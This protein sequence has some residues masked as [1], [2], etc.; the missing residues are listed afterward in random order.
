MKY[1]QNVH[2]R[3]SIRLPDYDYSQP[4]AYFI[5]L[6]TQG[7]ERS[8]GEIQNDEMHLSK[9][10]QIVWEIWKSLPARCPQI[11]VGTAIVMPDH[12][13]GIVKIL[14][15][16][17]AVHEPPRR[18][19]D[20]MERRRMTLPLVVG[21]LKMNTTKRINLLRGLEGVPVW[22]RNCYERIIRN[23]GEYARIHRYIKANAANSKKG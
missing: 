1:D 19:T 6:V 12:F 9:A 15:S 3:H 4:G 5:T 10:G 16:V 21:Y 22:Q 13:H 2:H 18:V 23:D 20:Q 11:E 17:G 14:A 7:R 8:F